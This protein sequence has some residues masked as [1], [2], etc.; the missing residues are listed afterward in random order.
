MLD[1]SFRFTKLVSTA[2]QAGYGWNANGTSATSNRTSTYTIN[3][4]ISGTRYYSNPGFTIYMESGDTG[5]TSNL[6]YQH[7]T[8][9]TV[10]TFSMQ[11]LA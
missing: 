10:Y 4:P 8:G 2:G 11:V 1:Y 9:G 5:V 6:S 3:S 7:T